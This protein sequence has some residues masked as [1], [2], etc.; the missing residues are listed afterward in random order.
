VTHGRAKL[1]QDVRVV[2]PMQD[3]AQLSLS[4]ACHTQDIAV[5]LSH[6]AALCASIGFCL[7]AFLFCITIVSTEDWVR[8][9][10]AHDAIL[11][12]AVAEGSRGGR[13]S[14]ELEA[15][16]NK[17]FHS[18]LKEFMSCVCA[19]RIPRRPHFSFFLAWFRILPHRRLSSFNFI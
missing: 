4:L 18:V 11:W 16:E 14:T 12:I 19:A 9:L 7:F 13:A 6:A 1:P 17:R 2:N 8:V 3:A 15:A 10:R 5:V